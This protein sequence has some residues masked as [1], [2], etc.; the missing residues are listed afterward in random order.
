MARAVARAGA[1][2]MAGEMAGAGAGARV[3]VAP[4]SIAREGL[5]SLIHEDAPETST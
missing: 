4:L 2:V 1:R 5:H 3:S